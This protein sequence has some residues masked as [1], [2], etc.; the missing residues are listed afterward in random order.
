M[1]ETQPYAGCPIEYGYTGIAKR[2]NLMRRFAGWQGKHVLD[3]GCG[4]GAY[5]LEIAREASS[6]FGIDITQGFLR[7]FQ[8]HLT[9]ANHIRIAQ[10]AS[11][12][13]PFADNSFDIIICIETLEHVTSERHTLQDMRRVLR[14][15]GVL[16]LAIPNKRY[17]FETHGLKYVR[18]GHWVPFASWLPKRV[19]DRIASARIY[20]EK[21]IR[22]LL[23]ETGWAEPRIEWMLPPL[24]QLRHATLQGLLRHV[25]QQLETTALRR[26]GV[27]LI[28]AAQ[29]AG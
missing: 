28:I 9:N 15:D 7:A 27:S 2:L 26:F 25:I 16:L 4:T 13:L 5:T 23:C 29:K 3:V 20:S 24:D 19:H 21:D 14:D 1:N 8:S 18:H 12:H 6:V 17:P 10:S 22:R 11:E